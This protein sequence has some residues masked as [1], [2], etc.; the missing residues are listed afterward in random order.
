MFAEKKVNSFFNLVFLIFFHSPGRQP[1]QRKLPFRNHV[2][3]HYKRELPSS[4]LG[5]KKNP[6]LLRKAGDGRLLA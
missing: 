4:I 3:H 1:T 5:G 6:L 2:P